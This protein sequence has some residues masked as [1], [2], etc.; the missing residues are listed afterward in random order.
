MKIFKFYWVEWIVLF[1]FLGVLG[2][3]FKMFSLYGFLLERD[4]LYLGAIPIA[5]L[6]G[7]LIWGH[8]I[9]LFEEDYSEKYFNDPATTNK[10]NKLELFYKIITIFLI[11][12]QFLFLFFGIVMKF[13]WL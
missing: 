12:V 6:G 1:V 9:K 5:S 10:H 7:I 3:V 8:S 11:A 4:L 13:K 2:M